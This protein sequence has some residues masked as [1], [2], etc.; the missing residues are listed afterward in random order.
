[1]MKK[2]ELIDEIAEGHENYLALMDSFYQVMKEK[3]S[4]G[5]KT[6]MLQSRAEMKQRFADRQGELRLELMKEEDND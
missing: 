2:K 1:M 4:A 3:L 6:R 5:D